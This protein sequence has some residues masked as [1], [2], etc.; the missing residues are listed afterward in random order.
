MPAELSAHWGGGILTDEVVRQSLGAPL[1]QGGALP[2]AGVD[3]A[4]KMYGEVS[5]WKSEL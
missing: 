1:W 4:P 3:Q 5:R 2:K